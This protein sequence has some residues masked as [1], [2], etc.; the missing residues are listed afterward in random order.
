M[1]FTIENLNMQVLVWSYLQFLLIKKMPFNNCK[2]DY[3]M[4]LI[5]FHLNLRFL[6]VHF[7][8]LT[9]FLVVHV[10]FNPEKLLHANF[11]NCGE[12]HDIKNRIC[13][14]ILS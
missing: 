5:D 2:V 14:I 4:S 6:K 12:G 3:L 7:S 13:T 1:I 8:T 9:Q 11:S 10:T